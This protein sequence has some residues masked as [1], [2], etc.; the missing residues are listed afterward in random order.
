MNDSTTEARAI[1]NLANFKLPTEDDIQRGIDAAMADVT[2]RDARHNPNSF[3]HPG[4]GSVVPAGAS[5]V[6]GPGVSSEGVPNNYG[7]TPEMP[8]QPVGGATGLSAIERLTPT[9]DTPEATINKL[10]LA[11]IEACLKGLALRPHSKEA[12]VLGAMLEERK[13]LIS[14]PSKSQGEG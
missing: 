14:S 4:E 8:F 5:K 10:S 11:E 6:V 2:R 9:Y 3:R 12:D 13:R 7:W 1:A